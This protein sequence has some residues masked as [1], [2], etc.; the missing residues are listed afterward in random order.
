MSV[1]VERKEFVD[2]N[3]HAAEAY[4]EIEALHTR[5]HELEDMMERLEEQGS[6]TVAMAEELFVARQQAEKAT[7]KAENSAATVRAVFDVLTD[8]LVTVKSDWKIE[9]CNPAALALFGVEEK[10]LLDKPLLSLFLDRTALPKSVDSVDKKPITNVEAMVIQAGTGQVPVEVSV[11]SFATDGGK[12]FAVSLRDIAERKSAE[13]KILQLALNDTL[14]GLANRNLFQRRL[15]SAIATAQRTKSKVALMYL[16]LDKFKNI[17]DTYGHPIGDALLVEVAER[18]KEA[19]RKTDTVARLGGDEFA[20]VATNI[21]SEGSITTVAERIVVAMSEPINAGGATVNTGTSIGISFYPQDA[22]DAHEL[23]RLA[24]LALYKAKSD[25][26]GNYHVYDDSLQCDIE[27]AK[28]FEN[29]LREGLKRGDF[30]VMYQPIVDCRTH[31]VTA[32][33]ALARWHHPTKGV[34]TP[35]R[36]IPL[37]EERGL[38]GQ[39]D[40]AVLM[41]ACRQNKYWQDRGLPAFRVSV[42]ISPR[43]FLGGALVEGVEE[44]L[45]KSGLS[46]QYLELEITESMVAVDTEEVTRKL[47]RLRAIGV[48]LAIDDFGTGFSSLS[49]LKRFPV[50]RLKIDRMFVSDITTNRDNAAISCSVLGL[51][52]SMGLHV[53]AEGVETAEQIEYL[54]EKGCDELQGFAF[55]KPRE[56]DALEAWVRENVADSAG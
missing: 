7:K 45:T 29:E 11:Q 47:E 1:Q 5:I 48:Q 54:S 36:F 14:T 34:L 17:N 30:R 20:I 15:N 28:T 9:T 52:H 32:V 41:E 13:A 25:G 10:F 43:Q 39:L 38:I 49:H 23:V 50:Q 27:E 46:A 33:E 24:D 42:N 2:E 16:D 19:T 51:G 3:P 8:A 31:K 35:D 55:S 22:T 4:A 18:L 26:R 12:R 44:A 37:A 56:P 21:A 40:K 53:V 6:E